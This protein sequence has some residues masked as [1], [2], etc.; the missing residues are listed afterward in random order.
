MAEDYHHC[1]WL[2]EELLP[3]LDWT[4]IQ[5][6]WGDGFSTLDHGDN[7][8]FSIMRKALGAA[9]RARRKGSVDETGPA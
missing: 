8:P 1:L 5:E 6:D 2:C 9:V 7:E 3:D 4:R